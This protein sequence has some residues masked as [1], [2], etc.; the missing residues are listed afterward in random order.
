[1]SQLSP[2]RLLLQVLSSAYPWMARR[3]LTDKSPELRDTLRSLL[4]KD[5]RFQFRRLEQ[6][7][8]QA[9]ASPSRPGAT[10]A[11]GSAQVSTRA[12]LAFVLARAHQPSTSTHKAF[13]PFP[14][15]QSAFIVACGAGGVRHAMSL[16]QLFSAHMQADAAARIAPRGGGLKFLLSSDGDFIRELLLDELAKGA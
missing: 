6:L 15:L 9:A 11:A 2:S 8:Q 5:G 13:E 4:Y 10:Y 7:L 14:T 12:Y 3:L 16:P 1:M